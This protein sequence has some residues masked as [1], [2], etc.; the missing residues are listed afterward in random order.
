MT[1]EDAIEEIKRWTP[2]L[3]VSGQCTEK[4]SK[5]Q[6]MAISAL[7][8]KDW[9]FYY[10]HG[11]AQAKRDLSEN[12]GEWIL[13]YRDCGVE[14]YRCSKCNL[15]RAVIDGDYYKSLDEFKKCPICGAN[16]RGEA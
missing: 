6:D 15:G 16:M 13:G 1:R 12:K 7:S 14:F 8:E 3:L 4:T 9:K 2:I 10:D 5:A 11:Y